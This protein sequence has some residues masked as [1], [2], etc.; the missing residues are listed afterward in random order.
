MSLFSVVVDCTTNVAS[1]D[2]LLTITGTVGSSVPPTYVSVEGC[3]GQFAIST[4]VATVLKATCT[5]I[6]WVGIVHVY[7][8]S[9]LT[10]RS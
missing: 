10:G 6:N 3:A 7:L 9:I 5:G 4:G 2:V 8:S 1:Q